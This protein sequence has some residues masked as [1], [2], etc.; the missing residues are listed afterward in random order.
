MNVIV[1]KFLLGKDKLMPEM[2]LK[3]S[4]FT[5]SAC[6]PLTKNKIKNEKNNRTDKNTSYIYKNDLD[7]A[8]FQ[9]DMAY[10]K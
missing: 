1:N 6:G 4:G 8:C 9:H 10:G 3:Q 5:Y 2:Q 7:K